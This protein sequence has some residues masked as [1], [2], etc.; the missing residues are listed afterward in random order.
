MRLSREDDDDPLFFLNKLG[1]VNKIGAYVGLKL[2]EK[3]DFDY[4]YKKYFRKQKFH[5]QRMN[6]K[7]SS[8]VCLATGG[9]E[10]NK[11]NRGN[12]FNRLCLS[13]LYEK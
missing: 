3:F 4:I 6:L 9:K 12:E 2:I 11:Y 7:P 10:W 8:V 1:L 5:C 13:S